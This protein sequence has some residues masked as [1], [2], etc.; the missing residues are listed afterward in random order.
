M[1]YFFQLKLCSHSYTTSKAISLNLFTASNEAVSKLQT[2]LSALKDTLASKEAEITRLTS[3]IE[4]SQKAKDDL[5]SLKN[6]CC[7][8]F[9]LKFVFST[10]LFNVENKIF[11]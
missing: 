2:E 1:F 5:A 10:H 8:T 11:M 3:E 4:A 9:L 7:L 6:V